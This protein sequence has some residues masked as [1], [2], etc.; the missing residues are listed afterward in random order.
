MSPMRRVAALRAAEHLDAQHLAGA[1]VVGD[2]EDGLRLDHGALLDARP[3]ARP[4]PLEDRDARASACRA[5]ERAVSMITHAVADA[6]LVLLVVRLVARRAGVRYFRYLRV[7]HAAARP[8]RPRSC[9]SCSLTTTPSRRL[10]R[11]AS[12]SPS[13][14]PLRAARSRGRIVLTRARSRAAL[15]QL[16]RVRRAGRSRGAG[17]GGRARRAS[18]RSLRVAARRRSG[19]AARRSF[20][21]AAPVTVRRSRTCVG[22]DSL[23]GREPQRLRARRRGSTPSISKSMRPGL[24]TAT[25]TSGAPLPLPMRVSAGFLVSGLSGKMRIQTRPP[26]LIVRV[27]ATRAASIWRAVSQPRSRACRPKSPNASDAAAPRRAA[28]GGPSASC[29]T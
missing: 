24:T 6:A 29:G 26:R 27:S 13:P 10:R 14:H 11:A 2:V 7:A 1:G 4:R 17:G 23:C 5:T 12:S 9:P 19:R 16:R 28:C 15:A 21:R 18:S 22:I 8:R 3:R 25:Q 20:M